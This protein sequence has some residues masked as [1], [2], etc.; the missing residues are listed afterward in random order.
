V[1]VVVVGGGFAGLA[2][3]TR[4]TDE[5]QEVTLLE[6]RP[7]LGGRACS[8]VD[9][10]TGDVIDN[11]QHLFLGCYRHTRRFL[12]RI[13]AAEKLRFR[14]DLQLTW[15]DGGKVKRMV[16]SSLPAPFHALAGLARAGALS[17]GE[18]LLALR[19]AAALKAPS[20][21]APAAGE[22][23]TVDGWLAR[24]SQSESARR[25]FWH[26]I[27]LAAL[28]DDPRTA[29]AQLFETVLR[30]TYLGKPEDARLAVAPSGLS[31]LY[32]DDAA[33]YLTKNGAKLRLSTA[34]SEILVES[35]SGVLVVKG[36]ALASGERIDA[37]AVVVALPPPSLLE[38]VP[39]SLRSGETYFDGIARLRSSPI[40]SIHLWLDRRVTDEPLFALA[41]SPIHWAFHRNQLGE[42]RDPSR[43]YLSLVT[44]AARDLIDRAPADLVA[45]AVSELKR[46]LPSTNGARLIHS[47]VIKERDA[48]IA[49]PA[50]GERDRPLARTPARGLFL[51]GDWIRTG[52]PATI[53]SAVRSADEVA[54]MVLAFEPP[55]PPPPPKGFVPLG[56]LKKRPLPT[57][58]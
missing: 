38:L 3:A 15:L 54:D 34:V 17:V 14:D 29:S 45:L 36:V 23:D 13:G 19:V 55:P 58:S 42:V 4:L 1:K 22:R 20:P 12:E 43:S 39:Q 46:A 21:L 11:G 40:V 33:R 57:A 47:R 2:A 24:L 41:G 48:T 37:E 52:L 44:S 10:T 26:P 9:E 49:H 6:K 18:R 51:A 56:N 50:G 27:A 30:E 25:N 53:E 28:N 5:G 35:I 31:Q 16:S 32:C 8:F 7:V